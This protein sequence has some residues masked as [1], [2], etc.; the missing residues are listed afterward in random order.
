VLCRIKPYLAYQRV[1]YPIFLILPAIGVL[2]F[3][4]LVALI[5]KSRTRQ[6][7]RLTNQQQ[8]RLTKEKQAVVQLV[9]I[10]VSFFIGYIP[11]IGK[12]SVI[13]WRSNG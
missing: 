9:L 10:I 4:V 5:V 11:Y 12:F 1:A 3:C 2:I 7:K 6:M 8:K 13:W